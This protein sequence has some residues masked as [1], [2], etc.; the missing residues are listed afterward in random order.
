ME[1]HPGREPDRLQWQEMWTC[2][3][4][5]AGLAGQSR[6]VESEG[7][8]WLSSRIPTCWGPEQVKCHAPIIRL[9]SHYW[10]WKGGKS[11]EGFF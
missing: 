4:F 7:A 3:L 1:A 11:E 2:P 6:G 5:P 10:V 9:A 8:S